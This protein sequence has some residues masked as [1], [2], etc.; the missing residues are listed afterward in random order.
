VLSYLTLFAAVD[1]GI[2]VGNTALAIAITGVLRLV[3]ALP[4]GQLVDR[5]NRKHLLLA[6]TLAA[7]LVHAATGYAVWNLTGLYVVLVIGAVV[8]TLDMIV[9]GPLFMDLLPADRRGEL[10]GVNM[11]LQNVFRAG[12]ALIGGAIFAWTGGYRACYAVALLCLAASALLLSRVKIPPP[13][14]P[15]PAA[16]AAG[17]GTD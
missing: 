9:A 10:T 15:G 5:M 3:L 2:S 1:L 4:A 12:G 13:P 16:E 8:G 17:G 11:V 14:E 7:G 6:T